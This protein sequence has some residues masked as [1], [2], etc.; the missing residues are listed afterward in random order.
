[1]VSQHH[2]RGLAA[3]EEPLRQ[4]LLKGMVMVLTI[5]V[6]RQKIRTE[7]ERMETELDREQSIMVGM[8]DVPHGIELHDTHQH[9]AE[10]QERPS[11]QMCGTG[12]H[13]VHPEKDWQFTAVAD[14]VNPYSSALRDRLLLIYGHRHL[15]CTVIT[16]NERIAIRVPDR[17]LQYVQFGQS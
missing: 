3:R 15:K 7:V 11:S 16:L 10:R 12:H 6:F 5:V 1:L 4:I 8:M 2:P 9:E 13:H 17:I 14:F